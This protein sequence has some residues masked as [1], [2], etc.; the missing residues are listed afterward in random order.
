MIYFIVYRRKILQQTGAWVTLDTSP[1]TSPF[2]WWIIGMIKTGSPLWKLTQGCSSSRRPR[3]KVSQSGFRHFCSAN[4]SSDCVPN[5]SLRM[6]FL[7]REIITVGNN[8]QEPQLCCRNCCLDMCPAWG[9]GKGL[10]EKD[11]TGLSLDVTW[12]YK[13]PNGLQINFP[14]WATELIHRK[15]P[16]IWRDIRFTHIF[17]HFFFLFFKNILISYNHRIPHWEEPLG[18]Y[19]PTFSG[20]ST[21]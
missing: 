16:S 10:G 3:N 13:A 19:D 9:D 4:S 14:W 6:V 21:V 1:K 12:F 8:F 18:S 5:V 20:I 17:S 7:H 2:V 11:D 15:I